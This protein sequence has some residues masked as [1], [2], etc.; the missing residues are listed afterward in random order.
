[1]T[2][3]YRLPYPLV[4][5]PT[6]RKAFAYITHGNRLLIF[7]HPLAPQAG[8]QVPAGTILDG[9]APE[10]AVLREAR[11]ETSLADLRIVRFLGEVR[12]DRADVGRAEIHHRFF[13]HLACESEPLERWQN[14]EPDPSDRSEPPLFEFWWVP[15]PDGVPGL[16]AGHGDMLPAL[17]E[18]LGLA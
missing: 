6:I 10:D 5:K 8:L 2:T 17:F 18:A 7:S 16:I 1:M 15:L 13:F 3:A 11:E 4:V 9:E 14:Y 12:R